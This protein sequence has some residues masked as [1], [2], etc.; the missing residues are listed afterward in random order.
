MQ[1]ESQLLLD[2]CIC[3]SYVFVFVF[4]CVSAAPSCLKT[5]AAA[6]AVAAAAAA[7]AAYAVACMHLHASRVIRCVVHELCCLK[8]VFI[9]P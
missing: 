2:A 4:R 7:Y 6:A 8:S 5:A 9:L 3:L 1:R